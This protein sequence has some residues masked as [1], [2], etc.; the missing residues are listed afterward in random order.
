[1]TESW[2]FLPA[3][4]AMFSERY[5]ADSEAQIADRVQAARTGIPATLAAIKEAAESV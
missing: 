4:L 1:M 3:G 2:E 5:G